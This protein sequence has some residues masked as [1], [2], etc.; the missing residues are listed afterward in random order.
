MVTTEVLSR[1]YGQHVDVIRVHGRVLVRGRA[2]G[3]RR[4]RGRRRRR[5]HR[6]VTEPV[7]T[8]LR[9]IVEP[10]F[11]GSGPVHI[12]LAV[13]TVIAVTSAV[14]GVFTVIRG[15]SFAGHS[16]ADI[17]TTGGSGAFLIGINQFWGYLAFGAGA[18]AFMEMIGMQ[19]RRG[20]DVATGV[21][22]G[23]ALGLAALFLY[24]G[25]QYST[26]TGA[27]FTILFGSMFVLTP[28]TVPV[29]IVSALLALVTVVALARVL[30]LSSLSPDLAA[31]RGVPVRAVGAAYLMALAVSVALS[32][33][34]IGAVLSTALLIG[35]A[36][37]ALRVAKGPVRAAAVA[38]AIGV[39]ATWLGI[40]LAYDS[41]YWPPGG[42]RLA[43]QLL[44]GDP[45]HRRLPGQLP[46]PG[47]PSGR[48][49]RHR[50]GA[51]MFGS[52][53]LNTWFAGTAVAVIAGVTGFFAV[54]RGSTFAAHAIPNGAFA[55]AA[56]AALLGLNPF[57]GL[58]VFSAAGA[59]G[60]AGLSRRARS[61][62]ATALTFVMMLGVGALFVSWSTQY[63]QEAYSLLFGEVFGISAAEVPPIAV[64]GAVSVAVIVVM[65]RPLLL[66]SALPEV[67]EARGVPPRRMELVF[68]LV[69]ALA[70]SMTVPVVGALLMFSL[71]IG[72]A[73]AARS[74][75][76]RPGLAI[77]VLSVV[78]A[79]V[80]VWAAIAASYQSN[81]PLGFFV[82]VIGAAFF[83]AGQA[84][85]RLAP[86]A[87]GKS[88]NTLRMPA[89]SLR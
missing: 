20:R 64:L 18:A 70:T 13:G 59:L 44:R 39:A 81:W 82:G 62:V 83:L 38:A 8:V 41:Y 79:L 49:C 24:L 7:N 36:A 52:F 27:S 15:Q 77:T 58:A 31:A 2:R 14:V 67:A 40:L 76:A 84:W 33:V 78:I 28:S 47:R 5:Q 63:A 10:G 16:L 54:L 51:R 86:R 55:G 65:F 22:L 56:G 53:M 25:T 75:T 35:P 34:I 43:G 73:A 66:S 68:L 30:L 32:A 1:L 4:Q 11:F 69:M 42:P 80:T 17:A 26:T 3:D 23:A 21:V 50:T 88:E 60:I 29:L 37:T 72:P 85:A 61:D 19:R 45:H 48:R 57:A 12:A 9:H 87:R 89:R 6:G 46:A 71:M 74:L